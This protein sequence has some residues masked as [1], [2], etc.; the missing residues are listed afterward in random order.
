MVLSRDD[1][2]MATKE[3]LAKR[4]GSRCSNLG[5]CQP[6]SGPQEDPTKA[7]NIGVA[8]HITAAS[9]D[10]SR[11]D[12]SLTREQRRSPDNGIWLYQA[13]AKLVDNDSIRY[14]VELLRAWRLAAE[15]AAR[16]ALERRPV[17]SSSESEIFRKLERLMPELLQ[18]MRNDLASYPIG[19][20]FVILSRHW[21]YW[22][23][24]H[25]LTYYLEDHEDLI[26]KVRLLENAGLVTN[27][28]FNSVDRYLLTERLV[29]YLTAGGVDSES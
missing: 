27:I 25:E 13:C 11:Y 6:T 14:P 1:F 19:R 23:R 5:C 24:G 10:G 22:A 29:D 18:E 2:S 4:V 20:E 12:P 17:R 26:G 15:A 3:L 21:T 28:K 16:D 8:A 7:I 9:P